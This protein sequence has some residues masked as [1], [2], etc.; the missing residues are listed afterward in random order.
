MISIIESRLGD[1]GYISLDLK[2][3]GRALTISPA[4]VLLTSF[5]N[6]LKFQET[7]ED[8]FRA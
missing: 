2:F 7:L 8:T 6:I 3:R 1:S 5:V 4:S